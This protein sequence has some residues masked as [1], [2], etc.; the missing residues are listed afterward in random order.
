MDEFDP[1][2]ELSPSPGELLLR[3]VARI[4]ATN[5]IHCI[6]VSDE[7]LIF[8]IPRWE[9]PVYAWIRRANRCCGF[10]RHRAA[11]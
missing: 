7:L 4:A 8:P 11:T 5:G 2:A 6:H 3:S 1:E 9:R 10:I